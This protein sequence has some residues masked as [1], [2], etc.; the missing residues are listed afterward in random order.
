MTQTSEFLFTCPTGMATPIPTELDAALHVGS[1]VSVSS[2]AN[3]IVAKITGT[4]LLAEFGEYW[5]G[6]FTACVRVAETL[7][8]LATFATW[9]AD[10]I[11]DLWKNLD[12]TWD[13]NAAREARTYFR[14]LAKELRSCEKSLSEMAEEYDTAAL[15]VYEGAKAIGDSVSL[16]IDLLLAAGIG[17]LATFL[18][19]GLGSF[20]GGSVTGAALAKITGTVVKILDRR[21]QVLAGIEAVL[22]VIATGTS[23]VA[24]FEELALPGAYDNSRVPAT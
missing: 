6:D 19:G 16:L 9:S 8:Q 13:G 12:E 18:S 24:Q 7:E 5:A 3:W 2:M 1:W 4:D 10:Q 22:A 20:L 21:S 14:G 17:A 23:A 11:D 15:G